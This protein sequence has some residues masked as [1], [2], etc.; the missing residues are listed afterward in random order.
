[1]RCYLINSYLLI[2]LRKHLLRGIKVKTK[3]TTTIVIDQTNDNARDL[4]IANEEQD[5]KSE[6]P[7]HKQFFKISQL[8]G[9]EAP[10]L[11]IEKRMPLEDR[12][13]KRKRLTKLRKQ[14]NIEAIMDKTF[15]FFEH[16]DIDKRPDIDWLNRYIVLAENVSNKTMQDLWAKILAGELSRPGLYSLKALKVFRDMSI[17]DAKLLAKACS[18]AV[19][20]H[21]KKN[22]RIIS[23]S[24]QQPGLFN[25]LNKDRQQY[26]NLSH[27][28]LN[29][30]D[31]L[32]LADNNLIFQQESES[33]AMTK[34]ETLTFYYNN[35]P[36]KLS[37]KNNNIALQFYKFTPIGTELANLI[38]E[39]PNDEFFATLKQ[40]LTHHF[41]LKDSE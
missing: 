15:S 10:L 27:F 36:L 12:S 39:K 34:G 8:L 23:G 19:K 16:K 30:A 35:V 13:N 38:T 29:Y 6:S 4:P 5:K 3:K 21:S 22:I 7:T 9:V 1:M 26:V 25:F 31:I 33:S 28:G 18:L 40:Q 11:P 41:D 37:S 17:T 2:L 20:D 32:A 14:E 24:Y